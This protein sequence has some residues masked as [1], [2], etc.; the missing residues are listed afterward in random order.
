MKAGMTLRELKAQLAELTAQIEAARAAEFDQAVAACRQIIDEYG[1]TAFDLGFVKT[2][3]IAPRRGRPPGTF[4]QKAPRP[5]VPPLYRDPQSGATWSGRG[6]TPR[7]ITGQ[8]RDAYL[9][10]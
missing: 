9:I 10:R 2:Q 5:P 1:L 6:R 8:N 7:W 4:K 3:T